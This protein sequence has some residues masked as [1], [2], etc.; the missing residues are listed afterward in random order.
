MIW[1]VYTIQQTFLPL[2]SSSPE[3]SD[4][5]HQRQELQNQFIPS[6][7]RSRRVQ[8]VGVGMVLS[9]DRDICCLQKLKWE[10]FGLEGENTPSQGR[11][12]GL[13]L[14]TNKPRDYLLENYS[15]MKTILAL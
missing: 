13:I 12:L 2:L 5:L 1:F 14:I 15:K 8:K 10:R 7:F 4:V 11:G 6:I 9:K 3:V